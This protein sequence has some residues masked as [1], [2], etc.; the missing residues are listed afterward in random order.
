MKLQQK[1][2]LR[3]PC[4]VAVV[5]VQEQLIFRCVAVL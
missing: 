3:G 5:R 1:K 4:R 2:F